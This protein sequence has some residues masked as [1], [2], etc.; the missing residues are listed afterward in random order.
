MRAEIRRKQID[1]YRCQI[2]GDREGKKY[3]TGV[4]VEVQAHH[5]IPRSE[6]GENTLG[7]LITLCDMCH[8][9]FHEQRWREYFGDKGV[10]ENMEW[11]KE[12]Y[13]DHV[14]ST[15]RKK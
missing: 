3:D 1:N 5:I 7:N 15:R 11:I 10:P 12:E 13:D 4:I 2:C 9:V 14:K 6:G 8:A